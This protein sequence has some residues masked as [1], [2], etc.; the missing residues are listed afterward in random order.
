MAEFIDCTSLNISFN[1]MGVATVSYTIV[2][3]SPGIKAYD[4]ISAGGQNFSGYVTSIST[5]QIPGTSNWFEN[6]VTLI[7]TT[8]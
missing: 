3:D 6:H 7:A 1:V 4:H 5:N 2:A 8:T